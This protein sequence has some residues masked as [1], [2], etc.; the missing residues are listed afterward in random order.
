MSK[1]VTKFEAQMR[2]RAVGSKGETT[3]ISDRKCLKLSSL[4]EETQ[5]DW[6]VISV[7]N[8]DQASNDQPVLEGTPCEAGAP[9][10]EGIPT[11]GLPISME[12]EREPHQE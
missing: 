6:V 9:L 4:D 11:K 1:L 5:K 2:K 7:D 12:L 10:E 3:P 8:P